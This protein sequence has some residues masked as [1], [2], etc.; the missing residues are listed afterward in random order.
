EQL[1]TT[2]FLRSRSGVSLT[3]TGTELL[4]HVGELF[5]ILDRAEQRISGLET[6]EVGSFIIGCH[7][8]LGAYFLP[9]FMLDF[10][11]AAPGI[12]ITLWNASS[13]EVTDAVVARQVHFALIVNPVPH[14]ELVLVNLFADAVEVVVASDR[15]PPEGDYAAA[16]RHLKTTQL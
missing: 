15:A 2:L 4:Q 3:S 11:T 16:A 8:S 7:E 9:T 14:P 13:A 6:A 5:A 1:A 12:E 10:S